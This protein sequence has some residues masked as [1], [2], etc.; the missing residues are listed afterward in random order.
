MADADGDRVLSRQRDV[1]S[2][3]PA[4]AQGGRVDHHRRAAQGRPV[5]VVDM[6]SD[7]QLKR[8]RALRWELVQIERIL[9][10]RNCQPPAD[11]ADEDL[12]DFATSRRDRVTTLLR[13]HIPTAENYT[14]VLI[15]LDDPLRRSI[16]DTLN[17]AVELILPIHNVYGDADLAEME[18]ADVPFLDPEVSVPETARQMLVD[19]ATLNGLLV[20]A[21]WPDFVRCCGRLRTLIDD[22]KGFL[23][24]PSGATSQLRDANHANKTQPLSEA[25]FFVMALLRRSKHAMKIERIMAA[26]QNTPENEIGRKT[27]KTTLLRLLSKLAD[28]GFVGRLEDGGEYYPVDKN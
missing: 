3:Y 14:G 23:Q 20:A 9:Q 21:A 28:M 13:I 19:Y 2:S 5:E 25:E 1:G 27:S 4:K 12:I 16:R 17:C 6:D 26:A 18:E 24:S 11:V 15:G 10:D 22:R 7:D 8:L